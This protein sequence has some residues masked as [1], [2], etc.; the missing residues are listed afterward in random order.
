MNADAHHYEEERL[1]ELDRY[2]LLDTPSEPNIDRITRITKNALDVPIAAVSLIDAHRQWFKSRQGLLA[3]ETCKDQSFCNIAIKSAEP[4]VVEDATTDPRFKDN[5]LVV[6]SPFIRAYCGAQLRTPEGYSLGALCAIDTKP[7]QFGAKHIALLTD[8]AAAVMSEFEALKIARIDGLTGA[9]TRRAFREE[10]E[11]ALALSMRHRHAL[12]CIVFDLDHFKAVNDAHGHAA[13][14]RVLIDAV[15]VC[16]Q[17]LRAS[18]ILGRVGGE[19]FA[20]ML[21]H[22][23]AAGA[24]KVAEQIRA[25]LERQIIVLSTATLSVQRASASPHLIGG[26]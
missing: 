15:G 25:A 8:L 12:S 19:E 21:P 7:R 18:D 14:D 24:L 6:G 26:P 4:L 11:R 20:M 23:D 3:H 22:T 16:Q 17:R 2:D 13:G 9:L 10:A 1:A 5:A